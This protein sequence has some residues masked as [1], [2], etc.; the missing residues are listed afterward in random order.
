MNWF[1][2]IFA[3]PTHSTGEMA[4]VTLANQLNYLPTPRRRELL[5]I[6]ARAYW[7]HL[8][9][10]KRRRSVGPLYVRF[11]HSLCGQDLTVHVHFSFHG[12]SARTARWHRE[13][14]QEISSLGVEVN[15]SVLKAT[16]MKAMGLAAW[17]AGD[18]YE[19]TFSTASEEALVVIFG[20]GDVY[21]DIIYWLLG[22]RGDPTPVPILRRLNL[23]GDDEELDAI[24]H[25]PAMI[26][27]QA[28]DGPAVFTLQLPEDRIVAA[29]RDAAAYIGRPFVLDLGNAEGEP[30]ELDGS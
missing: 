27:L 24:K 23:R 30:G 8:G 17:P 18:A 7:L 28:V 21:M 26:L 1:K 20:L 16:E 25:Y 9:G 15:A 12:S 4:P 11:L 22:S 5:E 14:A 3:K 19:I 29:A 10:Q 2:S 6:G 13:V